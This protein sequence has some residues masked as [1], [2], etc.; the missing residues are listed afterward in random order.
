MLTRFL[1]SVFLGCFLAT[2]LQARPDEEPPAKLWAVLIATSAHDQPKWNLPYTDNDVQALHKILVERGRVPA[3]QIVVLADTNSQ[4]QP[5]RAT[6][7]TQLSALL[8]RAAPPDSVLVFF[9]GHGTLHKGQTYLVP[10]DFDEDKPETTGLAIGDLRKVLGACKAG[11]KFLVLDCCHAGNDR[12]L[13]RGSIPAADVARSLDAD[14]TSGVI[15]L[16]SCNANQKSY[17]WPAR[18]QGIFTFWLCR[19]LEGAAAN[20]RGQVTLTEANNYVHDRVSR[21]AFVEYGLTQRPVL[22]GKLEGNPVLLSLRPELAETLCRRLA[23]HLD[24]DIRA[25]KLK[26]VGVLEFSQAWGNEDSLARALHPGLCAD[27]VRTALRELGGE[28]YEVP[29][30]DKTRQA[31]RDLGPGDLGRPA[32]LQPLARGTAALDGIVYGRLVPSGPEMLVE[33]Q[34]TATATGQRLASTQG[35]LPLSEESLAEAGASF[36][37][38]PR[39]PGSPFDP[40]V[41][42]FVQNQAGKPHPLLQNGFPFKLEVWSAP[43]KD[44]DPVPPKKKWKKKEFIQL[45]A[46]GEKGKPADLAI[47]ARPDEL[48]EIHV[49]NNSKQRVALQLLVDGLNTLGQTRQ[50]MRERL[51]TGAAW[52]LSPAVREEPSLTCEGWFFPKENAPVGTVAETTM[53]RF[54]FV[55]ISQSVAGRQKFGESLGLITAAFYAEQ[56]KAIGTGEGPEEKRLLKTVDF[57]S[58]RLEAVVQI[59][60]IDERDGQK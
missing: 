11:V 27:R 21:T 46:S 17:G 57:R 36:N 13:A 49:W 52:V 33:C 42:R 35:R 34:L 6:I 45:N 26:R 10:R 7:Q 22:F 24:L 43:H 59:R 41:V 55:D 56:G 5:T 38:G 25:K 47:A 53:K 8:A 23:A 2:G 32:R 12:S 37:N 30:A 44:G 39:P 48:Y 51:G 60:Y 19:A 4:G 58:G 9:A 14:E 3:E 29:P 54:R 20:E 31:V 50:E 28:V 18:R 40:K 1:C 15:V 16:A